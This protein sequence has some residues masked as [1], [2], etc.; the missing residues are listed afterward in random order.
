L[1]HVLLIC[2]PVQLYQSLAF[3]LQLH[4]G[5]L[6]EDLG[7]ALPQQLRDPVIGK[8]ALGGKPPNLKIGGKAPNRRNGCPKKERT[9]EPLLEPLCNL[10]TTFD[11]GDVSSA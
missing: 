6:L 1:I 7:I 4:L 9:R 8:A 10:G 2:H 5:I 3:H 11:S